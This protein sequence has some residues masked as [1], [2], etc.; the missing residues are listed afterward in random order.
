VGYD[1]KFN[2]TKQGFDEFHGFV[3]GNVD[4]QSHIDQV[5]MEDW[6]INDKLDDEKG[7]TTHLITNHALRFIETNQDNPFCLYLPHETPHYPFQGPNDPPDRQPG[8]PN[9][10]SGSRED[11]E[12]AY[13]E[14]ILE[15]DK[16]IG[17]I[18]EKLREYGLDKNTFLFLCSDNGPGRMG[19][20]GGLRGRKG[21]LWEGGH[22]VPA[23][24]V[25]P[26]KIQSGSK[27]DAVAMTMDLFPTMLSLTGSKIEHNI[28]FDG[29][30]LS[31]LLFER[32]QLPD[33]SLFWKHGKSYA[34]RKG[35]WKL[36]D[37]QL[38]NLKDDPGEKNDLADTY[39]EMVQK[40]Q[41]EYFNWD[42][43]VTSGVDRQS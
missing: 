13:R 39:P 40:F 4:Y 35:Q 42:K 33:R 34:I 7:Y 1:V 2:P 9:P 36:M 18:R 20:S 30:D 14:M 8:K 22:R 11:R 37:G 32:E 27:T 21:S 5:G 12:N 25:W 10:I 23:I 41:S 6:W 29:I 43:E 38:F 31:G 26:G 16:G 28:Q 15:M 19:S 17:K 24:A 3:S